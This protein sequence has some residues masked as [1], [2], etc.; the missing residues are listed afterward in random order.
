MNEKRRW[1]RGRGRE[2]RERVLVDDGFVPFVVAERRWSLLSMP[3]LC[4]CAP[5][6]NNND[7]SFLGFSQLFSAFWLIKYLILQRSYKFM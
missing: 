7:S 4:F 6:I 3:L 2:N 1:G 5:L